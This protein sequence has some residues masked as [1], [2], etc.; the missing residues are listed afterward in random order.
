MV[1]TTGRTYRYFAVPESVY[2]GMLAAPS[3]GAYFN[4]HVSGVYRFQEVSHPRDLPTGRPGP[5]GRSG[6]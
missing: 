6:G 1:F 2:G 5:T 3:C 4:R